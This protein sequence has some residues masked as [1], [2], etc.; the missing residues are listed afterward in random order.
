MG[1]DHNGS[2]RMNQ[3]N[4]MV[5][6]GVVTLTSSLANNYEGASSASPHLTIRYNSGTFYLQQP[7][8]ISKQFPTWDSRASHTTRV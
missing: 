1:T 6:N 3:T 5:S 7:I 4:V 2:A 8:T